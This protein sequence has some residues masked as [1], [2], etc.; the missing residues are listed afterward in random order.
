M[1]ALPILKKSYIDTDCATDSFMF[2][3]LPAIYDWSFFLAGVANLH[4]IEDGEGIGGRN[5][6]VPKS[7]GEFL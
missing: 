5:G 3:H 6:T 7:V 1:L 2:T 4:S